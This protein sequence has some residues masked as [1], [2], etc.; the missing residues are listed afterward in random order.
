MPNCVSV[1]AVAIAVAANAAAADQRHPRSSQST[2]TPTNDRG[3]GPVRL[4]VDTDAG[5]DVDDIGALAVAN[6]LQD[7]GECEIIA[8]AH[9]NGYDLAVGAVSSIMHFYD[10]DHVP[11]GAYKGPWV[12]VNLFHSAPWKRT[13]FKPIQWFHCVRRLPTLTT[14]R[15]KGC[16]T[17]TF[18]TS[19][20][21]ILALLLTMSKSTTPSLFTARSVMLLR[22]AGGRVGVWTWVL[23]SYVSLSHT[24]PLHM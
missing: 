6:A 22:G 5:F 9:T 15:Q 2:R 8:A 1:A 3:D 16:K 24:Y 14:R 20:E 19:S 10:R 21:I 7:N 13:V 4:I 12:S 17:A 18:R 11:L 23:G